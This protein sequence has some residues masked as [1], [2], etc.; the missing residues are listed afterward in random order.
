MNQWNTER[1]ISMNNKNIQKIVEQKI[2]TLVEERRDIPVQREAPENVEEYK[3][4]GKFSPPLGIRDSKA[5]LVEELTQQFINAVEL[6]VVTELYSNLQKIKPNG[7][8]LLEEIL[9]ISEGPTNYTHVLLN[10][11]TLSLIQSNTGNN[12]KYTQ[13]Q[14][15]G[16][17]ILEGPN[18]VGVITTG[19]GREIIVL[20]TIMDNPFVFFSKGDIVIQVGDVEL[21]KKGVSFHYKTHIRK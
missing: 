5:P 18:R 10:P 20:L 21:S 14:T 3:A 1:K 11:I 13:N 15:T 6:E 19:D 16:F 9:K 12:W 7:P 2:Q 4:I 17:S 8:D